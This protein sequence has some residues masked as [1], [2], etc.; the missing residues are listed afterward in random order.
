M[1]L[2]TEEK[3][4]IWWT[5]DVI[6]SVRTQSLAGEHDL[7][8]RVEGFF[9]FLFWR[10]WVPEVPLKDTCMWCIGQPEQGERKLEEP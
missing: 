6:C 2:V 10:P 8:C 5:L 1:G 7:A 3:E 4:E 9:F